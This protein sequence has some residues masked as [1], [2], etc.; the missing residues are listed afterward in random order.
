MAVE[1]VAAPYKSPETLRA[2][3]CLLLREGAAGNERC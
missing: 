3:E 1:P 2:I